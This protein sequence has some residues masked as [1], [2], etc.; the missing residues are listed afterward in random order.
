M[1]LFHSGQIYVSLSN[2]LTRPNFKTCLKKYERC[3]GNK[4]RQFTK[5]GLSIEIHNI[6]IFVYFYR[7][8]GHVM[9]YS[10]S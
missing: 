10:T 2:V 9:G 5:C 3:H 7:L 8:K 1:T 4:F 6:I